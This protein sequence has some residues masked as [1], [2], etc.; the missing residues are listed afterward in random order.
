MKTLEKIVSKSK[1]QDKF[2][3]RLDMVSSPFSDGIGKKI[4]LAFG[5]DGDEWCSIGGIG[6]DSQLSYE[7]VESYISGHPDWFTI[8]PISLGGTYL[9]K[10]HDDF[11]F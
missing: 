1:K 5:E 7:E 11:S 8:S 4:L 9:Y 6:R 10:P 2:I 3:K